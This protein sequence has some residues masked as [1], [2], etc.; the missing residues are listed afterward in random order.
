[1]SGTD[2]A[3]NRRAAREHGGA[4]PTCRMCSAPVATPR[5]CGTRLERWLATRLDP[6]SRP[7]VPEIGA[8]TANGMSSETVLFAAEWSENGATR[9]EALVARVAPDVQDVPVFPTYDLERQFE[10]I[11]RVG[12]LTDVPVPGR[13]GWSPTPTPLGAPFFVMERVDGEVPPDVMPYSF[14]DNWL[15]DA[16]RDDQRRLQDATVARA[17][18]AARDRPTPRTR[19]RSSASTTPG[20]TPCAATSPTPGPGTSSPSPTDRPLPAGRARASPG[21]R[22]LARSDEGEPSSA[23]A[24]PGSATCIYRDFEPVARPRLGD[25]GRRPARARRGLARLR[26]PG[27]RVDRRR[28]FEHARACRDFLRARGRRGDVRASSPA[29]DARATSTGTTSTTAS[30]GASSSCAPARA[31]STSARSSEPDDID[32]DSC[33]HKPLLERLLATTWD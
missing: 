12:D 8:T 22:P 17:R 16:S 2:E 25:G 23:G 33:H 15:F 29:Y 14:G 19:S 26:A 9:S 4:A 31:R 7:K 32:D 13:G 24:T 21:S 3:S 1:M 20:D 27:L 30:S 28:C 18:R 11:R 6:D 5:R 10:V